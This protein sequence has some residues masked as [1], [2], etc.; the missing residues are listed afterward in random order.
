MG[1]DSKNRNESQ[2]KTQVVSQGAAQSGA[3]ESPN[4]PEA[5][6]G[7][8][9]SDDPDLA[10][11]IATWPRLRDNVKAAIRAMAESAAR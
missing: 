6:R 2:G 10:C 11:V 7:E 5:A 3:V 8:A 4:H 1:W 9:T